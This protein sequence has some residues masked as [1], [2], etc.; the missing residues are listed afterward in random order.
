MEDIKHL[1][2]FTDLD[3]TLLDP[4]TYAWTAATRALEEIRRRKI[5]LVICSSKTRAEIEVLRKEINNQDPF[6]VENGGAI[7]MPDGYFP[8]THPLSKQ[9][10]AY[11]IIELGTPY[12]RLTEALRKIALETGTEIKGYAQCTAE[13]IAQKTGLSIEE[14]QRAKQRDY[15]EPFVMGAGINPA[16]VLKAIERTGLRWTKGSLYYHLTGENDKGQA[17]SLL[18]ELFKQRGGTATTIG[19]GDS[20]N[21]QSMLSVVDHPVLVQKPGGAYEE[22]IRPLGLIKAPGIGPVGWNSA[23]LKLLGGSVI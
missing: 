14:A 2:I 16:P 3:G 4:A 13:E 17:V 11:S 6:I 19:L 15:D 18:T 10:T 8:F 23:L 20:L 5:P 9:I 1:V 7:F 22:T 21:D 12:S